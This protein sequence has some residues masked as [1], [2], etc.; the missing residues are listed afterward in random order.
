M[1]VILYNY[2]QPSSSIGDV[3]LAPLRNLFQ[4]SNNDEEASGYTSS[5]AI[6]SVQTGLVSANIS[7]NNDDD[8]CPQIE[9]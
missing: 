9:A 2:G 8:L 5:A 6:I 1:V 3:S 7:D 4:W